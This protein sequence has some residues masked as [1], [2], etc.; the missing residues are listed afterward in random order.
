MTEEKK[1][2]LKELAESLEELTDEE[3][4]LVRLICEVRKSNELALRNVRLQIL[5]LA[6]LALCLICLVG[7]V[8]FFQEG[9]RA[10]SKSEAAIAQLAAQVDE[11]GQEV[12]E[13]PK[14]VAD[15]KGQLK[16]VA[17]VEL[18]EGFG[19]LQAAVEEE[20]TKAEEEVDE[21]LAKL[22]VASA[23]PPKKKRRP[24]RMGTKKVE[25]PI[26]MEDAYEK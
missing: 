17:E 6:V 20:V 18:E 9:L 12:D 11:V 7:L 13:G 25:I 23:A 4:P 15:D 26:A 3:G 21:A 5:S 1:R 24:K 14:I 16:I 2:D 8:F 22:G 10:L 19:E